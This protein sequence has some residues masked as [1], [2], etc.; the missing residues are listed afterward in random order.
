M[1]RVNKPKVE[2]AKTKKTKVSKGEVRPIKVRNV[3]KSTWSLLAN[4][5]K[6]IAKLSLIYGIIYIVL[7]QALSAPLSAV[8]IKDTFLSAFEN[9]LTA[10]FNTFSYILSNNTTN[11]SN[12]TS[13]I[14]QVV[15]ILLFSLVFIY[16]FRKAFKKQNTTV[17]ESMYQSMYPLIPYLVVLFIILLELIPMDIGL[18]LYSLVTSGG[19]INNIV[20]QIIFSILLVGFVGFSLYLL[21]NSIVSLYIVTL[22]D[23]TPLNSLRSAKQLV[24]GRRFSVILTILLLPVILLLV[25]GVVLIPLIMLIPALASWTYFILL[26][27]ALPIIHSYLYSL[28]RELIK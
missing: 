23:M 3:L 11:S 19:I 24:M 9:Q 17:K 5:K 8:S 16:V 2:E 6:I 10:S 22:K 1:S 25:A 13:G 20:E 12:A 4:N 7:V 27:I 28:Y 26:I 18:V 14:Y 21:S 15:L